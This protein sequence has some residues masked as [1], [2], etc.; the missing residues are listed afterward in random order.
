MSNRIAF[1]AFEADVVF[2]DIRNVH[3]TVLPPKGRVRISAPRHMALDTVR[4]FAL[5]KL[6]WIKA[7]REKMV[8]Q[9]RE[10]ERE[11][12]ERESHYVWGRRYL[13][14]LVE[15]N[16]VPFVELRHRTLVLSVRPEAGTDVKDALLS[17]W[18]RDQVRLRA[19]DLVSRWSLTLGLDAPRLHVQHMKTKWGSCSPTRRSIRL[20]TELAKKPPGCLEYIVVHELVHMLEPTHNDHFKALMRAFMPEWEDRRRELNLLPVRHEEWLY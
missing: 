7:Q 20:N 18:Y 17:R 9:E 13:L 16:S 19:M 6:A 2:K 8:A 12:L 14:K 15:S 1:G 10:E 5:S 4:V 11:F 3:L